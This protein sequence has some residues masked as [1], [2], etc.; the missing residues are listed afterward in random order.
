MML[1]EEMGP[2]LGKVFSV[3]AA[4]WVTVFVVL[5]FGIGALL[6]KRQRLLER[7]KHGGH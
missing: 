4:F 5:F 7:H 3:Y 1:N 6:K 2:I